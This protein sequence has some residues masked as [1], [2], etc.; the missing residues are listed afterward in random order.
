MDLSRCLEGF[1]QRPLLIPAKTI[2]LGASFCV[3]KAFL[4]L[5]VDGAPS[6]HVPYSQPFHAQRVHDLLTYLLP[7]ITYSLLDGR[8]DL[9][10]AV[11]EAWAS[12]RDAVEQ[13]GNLT[14]SDYEKHR[15]AALGFLQIYA[16]LLRWLQRYRGFSPDNTLV[17]TERML[18][19]MPQKSLLEGYT[20][21]LPMV[22]IPDV[23]LVNARSGYV[24][25][26]D[27]KTSLEQRN[28][29]HYYQLMAYRYV[30]QKVAT[31]IDVFL[32][33]LTPSGGKKLVSLTRPLG[34]ISGIEA[35]IEMLA[36]WPRRLRLL[37]RC[38]TA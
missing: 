30:L 20:D 18:V 21:F 12:V 19:S 29:L 36:I 10:G 25:L 38:C 33:Y 3:K 23:I 6:S 15:D 37:H 1:S 22:G 32:A 4:S 7:H 28:Q 8:Q 13:Y 16:A 27:W 24:A 26:I 5:M 17:Y 31:D 34:D 11:E 9:K 2:A 14:A 35:N